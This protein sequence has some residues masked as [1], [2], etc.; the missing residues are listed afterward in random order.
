MANQNPN[1]EPLLQSIEEK[2]QKTK[3]KVESTIREM[4]KQK[5]KINFNSVSV[6]SG[7]SKPFLYKYSEIRSRIETLRKQ[8]EKLDSPNQVKRNMTDSS[9]DVVI[10]SLRK[11][12][13][14]LEEE[15]KKL[16]E[17][18]KVDWAAIYNELN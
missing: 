10:E 16:K 3:Q 4:I 8:E 14:H 9:K 12:V 1:T 5:E 2:K 15:N 7:V 13:K 18:L 6:K 11:K 17:Q